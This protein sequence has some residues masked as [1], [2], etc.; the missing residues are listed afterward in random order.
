MTDAQNTQTIIPALP[1]WYVAA[2]ISG[3]SGTDGWPAHFSL[4]P[5][6][7]W[8]I[9]REPPHNRN[10]SPYHEATAITLEGNMSR[11]GNAWAIKTP[12]NKFTFLGDAT[13]DNE[14]EALNYAQEVYDEQL[15]ER[16]GKTIKA[17]CE[18]LVS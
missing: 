6:V 18:V 16:A 3:L 5:I 15:K 10:A 7:A 11:M 14:A 13:I 9:S 8:E 2:Y 12:D 17:D 4:H 1:G